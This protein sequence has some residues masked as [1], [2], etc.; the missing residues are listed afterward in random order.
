VLDDDE[1]AVRQS[2]LMRRQMRGVA[3]Q[4]AMDPNDGMEL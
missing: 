3:R 1:D 4:V 2:R